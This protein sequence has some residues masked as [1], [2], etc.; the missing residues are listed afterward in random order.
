ML[1]P[2]LLGEMLDGEI[3]IARERLA[4]RFDRL[5]RVGSTVMCEFDAGGSRRMALDGREYDS[6]PFRL[7]FLGADGKP[8]SAADWPPG[9]CNGDH[10][11][12]KVPWACIQGTYEYSRFPGHHETSWDSV[13]YQIRLPELL[14]HLLR[15]CGR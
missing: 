7:S 4:G 8:L 10:P 9:I 15:R 11:V 14:D 3:E 6:E 13:R 5:N 1:H 12:L 2:A